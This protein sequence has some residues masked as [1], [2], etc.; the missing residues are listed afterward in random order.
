MANDTPT[1]AET[2][3]YATLAANSSLAALA[4][5]HP[6]TG[7]PQI[8]F[9]EAPADA[10]YPFIVYQSLG[11]GGQ[12]LITA[13]WTIVYNTDN[14]IVKAVGRGQGYLNGQMVNDRPALRQLAALIKTALHGQGG[15]TA[16]G[17]VMKCKQIQPLVLPPQNIDGVIYENRGGIYSLLLQ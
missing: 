4:G 15:T 7:T 13:N 17:T 16:D 3:I 2:W 10:F 9:Q 5:N 6:V 12:N 1:I 8:Y 14:Y 11:Q